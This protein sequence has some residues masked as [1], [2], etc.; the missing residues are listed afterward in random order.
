MRE[1]S[2]GAQPIDLADGFGNLGG[3]PND[4][5][6][7]AVG[8]GSV[9]AMSTWKLHG[10]VVDQQ[11]VERVDRGG[12]PCSP[13]STSPGPYTPLDADQDRIVV[14][15]TNETRVLSSKG[16]VLLSVATP[17]LAAQLSGSQLVIAAGNELRVYDSGSGNRVAS[18]P[19][20]AAPIGHDCFLYADPS[21]DYG[22]PQTQVTLED[23]AHGLAAYI[24][25]GQVHLLRLSDGADRT[26]ARGTLARFTSTGLVYADGAR[27]WLTPYDRLPLQSNG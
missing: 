4:G 27:I 10:N 25:A 18:W 2:I 24:Y 23:V 14:S 26:V 9:L 13:M 12:C 16:D 19:M 7:T 1:A 15:G 20:P 5:T 22:S 11:T 21:C 8:S 17:T 3:T 6:G